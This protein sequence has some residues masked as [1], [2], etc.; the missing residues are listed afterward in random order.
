VRFKRKHALLAMSS[1]AYE[2]VCDG[3]AK[4]IPVWT[5]S[6]QG[7]P[8]LPEHLQAGSL[9]KII[10][11]AANFLQYE[12]LLGFGPD[13]GWVQDSLIEVSEKRE[14]TLRKVLTRMNARTPESRPALETPAADNG[15]NQIAVNA[16]PEKKIAQEMQVVKKD[17]EHDRSP[18]SSRGMWQDT[19]KASYHIQTMKSWGLH[20]FNTNWS[21]YHSGSFRYTTLCIVGS[22]EQVVMPTQVCTRVADVRE[23]LA[24]RC[25]VYA[26][27]LRFMVK[28]GCSW[29]MLRNEEE[30]G[31]KVYVKGVKSFRPQP[32]KKKY[33][34]VIIGCGYNGLKAG[35]WMIETGETDFTMF[36][37]YDRVGGHAWLVQANKTSKLQTDLA[38]FHVWY[39]GQWGEPGQD[40]RGKLSYP[41]DWS[42]WP[43]KDEVIAHMQHCAERS[44][45]L[46]YVKLNTEIKSM[47]I[48][49]KLTDLDRYYVLSSELYEGNEK[50]SKKLAAKKEPPGVHNCSC[51]WH[52]P[53]A[54][55]NP[56]VIVYPGEEEFDGHLSYGMFDDI[57]Y[58]SIPHQRVAILGNGAF[59]VENIRTCMEFGA[60]KVFLVTRRKN[61]PSPRLP[62]WFVHQAINPVPA[63]MV[64][65]MFE[66][67][68]KISGFGDPWEYHS[69]YGRKGTNP[70]IKSNSRFG[71]GDV[72]FL[73]TAW[74]R[75]EYVVDTVKRFS[76]HTVHYNQG[77]KSEDVTIVVKAL[78]LLADFAADKFHKIKEMKGL[79]PNGDERR[80]VYCDA[81]G[82]HAANFASF[83]AGGGAYSSTCMV[84][85]LM[86]FPMEWRK[87]QEV[88]HQFPTSVAD[89]NKPAHQ[90]DAN[91]ATTA[92][93]MAVAACPL[94]ASYAQPWPAYKSNAVWA[95]SPLDRLFD[96]CKNSW[97]LYQMEWKALGFDHDWVP[98]PYTLDSVQ[99][100]FDEYE[101]SVGP[102]KEADME[103]WYKKR[104]EAS[105]A[106]GDQAIQDAISSDLEWWVGNKLFKDSLLGDKKLPKPSDVYD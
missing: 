8:Q 5:D 31:G 29:K 77:G 86:D 94:T 53:G 81:L 57:P 28:Q 39:G 85:H 10:G 25:V 64:L 58:H 82:M 30:I 56:R 47:E 101:E 6:S 96:E 95:A 17:K 22:D 14:K 87:V 51:V 35:L 92:A 67:M 13:S 38:A 23:A 104:A 16:I 68:F 7:S 74:G 75:C 78:G 4:T 43:K 3:K 52:Y 49:G 42:T 73:A 15:A 90:Y 93:F 79:W 60:E 88:L 54:Y 27:Q 46:N 34:H 45:I 91:Y 20:V 41:S 70:T 72:T 11:E 61:L 19:I 99:A 21:D 33:P 48:I 18:S 97:D 84:K 40:K 24:A 71:I 69:V 76:K 50:S 83:S 105:A 62:C 1:K 2:V 55:F 32:A 102:I 26:D 80:F 44:G 106:G 98:Y 89:E 37:K 66:P 63:K 9:V 59:A 65:E 100:W 12:L 36:E 103:E